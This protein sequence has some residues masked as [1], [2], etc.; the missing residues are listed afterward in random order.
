M[1]RR[2]FLGGTA[3]FLV[4]IVVNPEPTTKAMSAFLGAVIASN[5]YSGLNLMPSLMPS[6]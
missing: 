2:E 3:L 5:G 1:A 4:N 6:E